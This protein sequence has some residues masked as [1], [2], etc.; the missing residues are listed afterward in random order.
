MSGEAIVTPWRPV[1]RAHREYWVPAE[2]LE[3]FNAAIIAR[4]EVVAEFR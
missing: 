3:A 1:G 2:Q 4:I